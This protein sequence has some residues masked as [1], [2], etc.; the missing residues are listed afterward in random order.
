MPV[1]IIGDTNIDF[2]GRRRI[3]FVV[4]VLL[5]LLGVFATV[6]IMGGGGNLGIQF[7]GGTQVEGY[8]AD[9]VAIG[10][11]RSALATGGFPDVEIVALRGRGQPNFFLIRLKSD[12]AGDAQAGEAVLNVIHQYFPDNTFTMDSVHEVGP[13][14]GETLKRDALKAIIISLVGILLYIAIR[15]DIRF[16]VAATM[17]TFHDVLAVLGFAYLMKMEITILVVSALLTIAGYSLTDTVVVYDR[18][19]ENLRKYHRKGD[20]V[21]AINR[22]INEVL[23]RTIMTSATT[24][25]V[26]LAIYLVGGPVLRDFAMV[27]LMGIVVGSYSSWFVASSVYIEWENRRPKRFRA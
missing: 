13:A 22:S 23:S 5:V 3:A 9:P 7:L 17:A 27:M 8:F 20:F 15:F 18:I 19:R 12:I 25:V 26:V 16:G 4:S 1:R 2:I 21:P 11:L 10:D 6:M 24:G 14:V